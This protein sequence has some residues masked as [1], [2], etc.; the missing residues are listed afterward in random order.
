MLFGDK[1]FDLALCYHL[2]FLYMDNL[3]MEFYRRLLEEFY[4][5]SNEVRIFSLMDVNANQSPCFDSVNDFFKD[6]NFLD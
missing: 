5:V 1:E 6:V 3:S 4:R 2:L